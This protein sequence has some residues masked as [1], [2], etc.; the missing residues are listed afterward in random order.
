[1]EFI[2]LILFIEKIWYRKV[3]NDK[4]KLELNTVQ[5]SLV[6]PLLYCFD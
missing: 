1:M 6:A 4:G 3:C 5:V 2:L